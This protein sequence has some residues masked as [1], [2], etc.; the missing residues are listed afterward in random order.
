MTQLQR[1]I[2]EHLFKG[3][4]I[5]SYGNQYRLRDNEVR[6]VLK[7]TYKTFRGINVY[8]RRSPKGFVLDKRIVRQANG[9]TWIK[10]YYI[11]QN[12]KS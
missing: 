5:A 8:L 9:N 6:P 10:K 2:I 3:C 4:T 1:D 11:N 7:F 12:K